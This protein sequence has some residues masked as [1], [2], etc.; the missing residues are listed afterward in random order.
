MIEHTAARPSWLCRADGEAWPCEK[1]RTKLR[2]E[3]KRMPTVTSLY[4]SAQQN[5]FM[6]DRPDRY[7]ETYSRFFGWVRH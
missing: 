5:D 4:L 1:A 3:Y 7:D 6:N 2:E